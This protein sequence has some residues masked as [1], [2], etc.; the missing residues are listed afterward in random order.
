MEELFWNIKAECA[1]IGLPMNGLIEEV[2]IPKKTWYRWV[3]KG[4]LPTSALVKIAKYLHKSTDSLLG[5]TF[6]NLEENK[7]GEVNN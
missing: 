5:M 1:R 3:D 7:R 6:E 4:D 2:N